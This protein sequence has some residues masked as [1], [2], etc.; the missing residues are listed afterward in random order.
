MRTGVGVA[1]VVLLTT[2]VACGGTIGGLLRQYEYEEEMY[3]AL[4]GSA[5][6]FVSSSVPALNALRGTSF[7]ARPGA[8]V[9]RDAVRE[10]FT[11]PATRVTRVS[12][13]RRSGR[14]FV[15]VRL[16]VADLKRL[17]EA[18]PF[19]WSSYQLDRDADLVAYRQT[20]GPP[21]AEGARDD[22]GATRWTGEE[23]VA[24]RVHIPSVVVYHNAG[25]ANLRRGNILVWEQLL[26]QRLKGVPLM[27]EARMQPQS[28]L[29]RTLALFG[30]ML[31][32]VGGMFALIIWRVVRKGRTG[33]GR[34]GGAGTAGA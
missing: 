3:L 8:R 28:I 19:G 5:T 9:D 13:S 32:A 12:T 25:P 1:G 21:P 17:G 20:V 24:F 26:D 10:Y 15:H 29:S 4:D 7:E 16:A 14:Q 18:A 30:A 6:V 2:S 11:S 27:L 23:L 22:S 31:A 33:A 34:A